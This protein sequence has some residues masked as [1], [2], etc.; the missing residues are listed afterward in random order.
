M[1]NI[2]NI[3]QELLEKCRKLIGNKFDKNRINEIESSDNFIKALIDGKNF[4]IFYD[5][6]E[7]NISKKFF[8]K[9]VVY[10]YILSFYP[11]VHLNFKKE[12]IFGLKYGTIS[13]YSWIINMI[14]FLISKRIFLP[15]EVGAFA[16]F[17]V[18]SQK[19]YDI[20]C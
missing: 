14:I 12:L 19:Q 2:K 1:H 9:A 7:D 6:L 10:R 17:H 20:R 16:L 15:K 18:F 3:S 5:M 13:E 8:S 11:N 4:D